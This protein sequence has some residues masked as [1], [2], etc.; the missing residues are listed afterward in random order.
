MDIYKFIEQIKR[1]ENREGMFE[2]LVLNNYENEMKSKTG[3][4]KQKETQKE[5]NYEDET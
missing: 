2:K 3:N 5:T 4:K 1:D